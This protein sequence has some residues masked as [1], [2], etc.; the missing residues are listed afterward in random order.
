[1]PD[2]F[3]AYHKWLGISPEKQPPNHYQLLAIDEFESDPDVIDAAA[4]QRM[5]HL[6]T[7]QNSKHADLSQKLLNDVSGARLTL[8]KSEKKAAYDAKL[9]E[10]LEAAKD[11]LGPSLNQLSGGIVL[12]APSIVTSAPATK[13]APKPTKPAW[14]L[15]VAV[16]GGALAILAVVI[17]IAAGNSDS[18]P[19]ENPVAKKDSS[20]KSGQQQDASTSD[21]NANK[22]DVVDPI[23]PPPTV[24]NSPTS[25]TTNGESGNTTDNST[26]SNSI[27]PAD[28]P[29]TI[30]NSI[31]MKLTLIPAG[32][33]MMGSSESAE[34]LAQS[35][36]PG[37]AGQAERF[38]GE[39][40]QHRVK[41]TKPY[42]L[43]IYEV[44]RGQ[45]KKVMGTEPWSGWRPK[46]EG[47]DYP[48]NWIGW[49]DAQEPAPHPTA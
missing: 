23:K 33:F 4:D 7:F 36:W 13:P 17:I 9:K 16:S 48:V 42:Y 37:I 2:Q 46:K 32:Q 45:W 15:P 24:D 40:P 11:P 26:T 27:R 44:T 31:G 34:T 22:D 8:L 12:P 19:P 43:G 20:A 47:A 41:I 18:D 39:Y 29:G 3:D 1:M 5:S 30:T 10:K 25:N 49:N 35:F 38:K 14:V 21:D 6:R 28:D